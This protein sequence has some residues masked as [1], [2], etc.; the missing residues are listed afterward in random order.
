MYGCRNNP[1]CSATVSRSSIQHTERRA[2]AIYGP[3]C[4][5]H[6][7]DLSA[8]LRGMAAEESPRK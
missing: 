5:T 4:K 2:R 1:T 8:L 3:K 7:E 6:R